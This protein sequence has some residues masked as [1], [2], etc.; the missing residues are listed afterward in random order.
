MK[1]FLFSM[2]IEVYIQVY[3]KVGQSLT[4]FQWI[5]NVLQEVVLNYY[6]C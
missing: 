1:L 5:A 3:L 2:S 6:V 4:N